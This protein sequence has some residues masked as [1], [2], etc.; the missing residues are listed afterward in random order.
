MS[1]ERPGRLAE[2]VELRLAQIESGEINSIAAGVLTEPKRLAA[3]YEVLQGVPVW[4][5]HR[6]LTEQGR[7]LLDILQATPFEGLNPAR[8][9]TTPVAGMLQRMDNEAKSAYAEAQAMREVRAREMLAELA[10]IKA[11]EANRKVAAEQQEVADSDD[12]EDTDDDAGDVDDEDSAQSDD[13]DDDSAAADTEGAEQKQAEDETAATAE[14]ADEQADEQAQLQTMLETLPPIQTPLPS[15][16]VLADIEVLLADAYLH[17]ARHR[18]SGV[19]DPQSLD[20]GW[21]IA[22]RNVLNEQALY[23][24][25][26]EK[27][28]RTY[29]QS[30]K[31]AAPEY[32]ALEM[33]LQRYMALHERG[34]WRAISTGSLLKPGDDDNRVPALRARLQLSGEL[35][36]AEAGRADDDEYEGAVVTAVKRFQQ[37]HG[38]KVDG[39]VGPNTVA[40]LNMTVT[41]KLDAIRASM[42]RWRWLPPDLGKRHIRVN[43]AGYY[44][45]VIENG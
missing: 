43:V 28:S 15:L 29:L 17:L 8:Y 41:Q 2:N 18:A 27:K 36:S 10:E 1:A 31:P 21:H 6:G 35:A 3:L 25:V 40:H 42:E 13:D 45:Q 16:D 24:A 19:V 30:L 14:L 33:A 11:A 38:L 4:V 34:G 12:D 37:R 26:A 32:L 22:R 39:I 5:D 23:T 20:I 9:H 44:M 7:D